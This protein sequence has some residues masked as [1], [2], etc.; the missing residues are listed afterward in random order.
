MAVVWFHAM[1]AVVSVQARM[2]STR[3]PGK[4]LLHLGERRVLGWVV[5]RCRRADIDAETV[6]TTGEGPENDA[7]R[8]WCRRHDV[9]CETG[10]E[11]DLLARHRAVAATTGSETLIRV[12]GDCPFVPSGEIERIHALHADR[13]GYTTN[14]AP[15][16]AVGTA[17]DAIDAAVLD[18]LAERGDTH[19]VERLRD[20]P[21]AWET[22]RSGNADWRLG[23]VHLAVDTPADYWRLVDAAAAAGTEPAAVADWLAAN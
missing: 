7:I 9:G 20:E 16:M 12:T 3:L 23:D 10:P 4:V 15:G 8:E 13:G 19:P 2:G 6:V 5:E 11:D 14:H 17:V 21:D 18:A 22:R 1:T